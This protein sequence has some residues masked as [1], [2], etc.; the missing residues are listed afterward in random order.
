MSESKTLNME[1][2]SIQDL[3]TRNAELE[4]EVEEL[5]GALQEIFD[6]DYD[7]D[8]RAFAR[9]ALAAHERAS[10]GKGGE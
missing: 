5:I 6:G 3:K 7:D 2:I 8:H 4:G 1:F 10:K 9:Q